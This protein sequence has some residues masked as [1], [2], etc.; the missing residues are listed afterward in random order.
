MV[1]EQPCCSW[2]KIITHVMKYENCLKHRAIVA[3]FHSA[4][5]LAQCSSKWVPLI[6][7]QIQKELNLLKRTSHSAVRSFTSACSKKIMEL[8]EVSVC[9]M[10]VPKSVKAISV[11]SLQDGNIE[12]M[13]PS[14]WQIKTNS[15]NE[16]EE[17]TSQPHMTRPVVLWS[18]LQHLRPKRV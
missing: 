3:L 9:S 6:L 11:A 7:I 16:G 14:C 18:R 17:A 2:A 15:P 13:M 10:V 8:G 1:I 4:P 12:L 5:G